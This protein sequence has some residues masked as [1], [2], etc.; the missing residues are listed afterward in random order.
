MDKTVIFI[1]Y[2]WEG[3]RGA[4]LCLAVAGWRRHFRSPYVI[5]VVGEGV[6]Y[7]HGDDVVCVE[8]PRVPAVPF[9]YR[10][11]LDYV[12]CMRECRRLYPDSGGFIFAADD[13]YLVRDITVDD[14]RRLRYRDDVFETHPEF[15]GWKIDQW[16]TRQLLDREGLPHRNF[17]THVPCWFDWARLEELWRRYD[18]ER[19]SYVVENLYYNIYC[20]DVPAEQCDK[21]KFMLTEPEHWKLVADA[22]AAGKTWI[23]AT[24]DGHTPQLERVL[25][26]Y[27]GLI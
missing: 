24:P 3:A 5:V 17:T 6:P 10:Q 19:N 4:E 16:R 2:C 26:G 23:C 9:M 15:G 13:N 20:G 22:I 14:V 8:R 11:H 21:V 7:V 1:P 27:Y 25:S 12:S 18:M